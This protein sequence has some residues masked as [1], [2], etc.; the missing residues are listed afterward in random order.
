MLRLQADVLLDPVHEHR[1]LYGYCPMLSG[2]EHAV[3]EN[4]ELLQRFHYIRML[5]VCFVAYICEPVSVLHLFDASDYASEKHAHLSG[6]RYSHYLCS[7][8]RS[9]REQ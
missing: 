5:R 4:I 7:S 2:L 3:V 8:Y 9:G 6:Y 1:I